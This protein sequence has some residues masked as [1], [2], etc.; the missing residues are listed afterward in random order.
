MHYARA[1]SSGGGRMG[2]LA[3]GPPR[4][5]ALAALL[6]RSPR[7]FFLAGGLLAFGFVVATGALLW[8]YVVGIFVI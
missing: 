1:R 5:L 3:C 4:P 2:S 8:G 7:R 6:T